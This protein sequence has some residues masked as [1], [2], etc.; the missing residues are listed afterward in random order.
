MEYK[1]VELLSCDFE[2]SDEE[3]VRQHITYR[4][5]N[6]KARLSLM[7]EKLVQ[8]H[9]LVSVL[10]HEQ[11]TWDSTILESLFYEFK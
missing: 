2:A 4:Y 10:N 3:L 7:E 9:N 8:V 1:F 11:S 5:N 6:I